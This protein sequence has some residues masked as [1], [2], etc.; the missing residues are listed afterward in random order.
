M[1]V[2]SSPAHSF[3]LFFRKDT[4]IRN[5]IFCKKIFP[6]FIHNIYTNW[7]TTIFNQNQNTNVKASTGC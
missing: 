6:I 4:Q 2:R 7:Q 1:L 3:G 5:V